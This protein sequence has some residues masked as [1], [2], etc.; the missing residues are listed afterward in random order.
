MD[1]HIHLCQVT[2]PGGVPWPGQSNQSSTRTRL[3]ADY[4]ALA[5]KPLGIVGL[6]HRR[7]E[8]AADRHP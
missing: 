2:R 4:E 3:P 8:P 7:G 1:T 5:A 6:G